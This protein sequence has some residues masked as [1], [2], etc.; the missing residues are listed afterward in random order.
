[1]WA[2]CGSDEPEGAKLPADAVEALD[3]RLD[4]ILRRFEEGTQNA[5]VGACNQ[6]QTDS[7]DVVARTI[8]GLPQDVDEDIRNALTESFRTL[9]TLTRDG[10]ADAE[11]QQTE[12]ETTPE[13]ETTPEETATEETTPEPTV[14]ETTPTT[15]TTPD[16]SGDGGGNNQGGDGEGGGSQAPDGEDDG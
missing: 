16:T 7:F 3:S 8:N 1:M 13:P 14:P 15:P 9:Q 5:N 6:I 11:N 12:T 10:C 2:G 4:E